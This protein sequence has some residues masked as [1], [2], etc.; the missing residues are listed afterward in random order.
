M[1]QRIAGG[2]SMRRQ[3]LTGTAM[4]AAAGR[5]L[6]LAGRRAHRVPR[7]FPGHEI[8][9]DLDALLRGRADRARRAK[10]WGQSDRGGGS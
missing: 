1:A 3:L 5:F 6:G 2:K 9:L 8:W 7:Q 4:L 10:L